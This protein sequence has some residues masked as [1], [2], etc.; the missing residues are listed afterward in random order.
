M[1]LKTGCFVGDLSQPQLGID[2][3]TW[4]RL[5]KEVDVVIHNGASVHWVKRYHEMMPPNVLSTIDAMRLCKEGKPKRFAFVNSTAV[6]DSDHYIKLSEDLTRTGQGSI[7]EEDDMLGSRTGLGTGYGQTKCVSEQLIREAGKR[8]LQGTIIR[9][10]Y[11]LGDAETGVCNVDDFM[12]R[13]LKRC[14]SCRAGRASSTRST[15]CRSSTW[16]G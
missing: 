7:T 9:P 11:I 4:K 12:I 3:L 10:G 6:L 5:S 15:P 2:I 13:M 8:G 1:E 14:F 16:R